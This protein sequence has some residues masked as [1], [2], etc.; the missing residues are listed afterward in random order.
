MSVRGCDPAPNG[1]AHLRLQVNWPRCAGLLE[2]TAF[3]P[4]DPQSP[5]FGISVGSAE[6]KDVEL[7]AGTWVIEARVDLTSTAVTQ[8]DLAAGQTCTIA[9]TAVSRLCEPSTEVIT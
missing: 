8:V 3:R 1:A 4:N 9:V 2:V 5:H 7:P 6:S